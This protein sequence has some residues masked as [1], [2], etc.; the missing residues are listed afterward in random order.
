MLESVLLFQFEIFCFEGCILFCITLPLEIFLCSSPW[1]NNGSTI[2]FLLDG[3]TIT[4]TVFNVCPAGQQTLIMMTRD[5]E[6][7]TE[8]QIHQD[9]FGEGETCT[10]VRLF[11]LVSL[12]WCKHVESKEMELSTSR[13]HF[14]LS[15]CW[16]PEGHGQYF[17]CQCKFK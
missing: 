9:E 7:I 8:K 15:Y 10:E 4:N 14:R 11:T 1:Q 12:V 16:A 17:T 5:F 13:R 6:P 2:E 3:D